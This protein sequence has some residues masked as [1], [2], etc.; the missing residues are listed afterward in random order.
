MSG[1]EGCCWDGSRADG[2]GEISGE[3]A[4]GRRHFQRA[5]A[6]LNPCGRIA[7]SE[8]TPVPR[9]QANH[10]ADPAQGKSTRETRQSIDDLR[11]VGHA[12]KREGTT[13]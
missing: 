9:S 4:P 5:L 10:V 8:K 2:R 3:P 1:I 6:T 7:R 11:H 13:V 12:A